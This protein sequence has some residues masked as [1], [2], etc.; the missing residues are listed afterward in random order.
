LD[1]GRV[2]PHIN[3]RWFFLNI[4]C[5]RAIRNLDIHSGGILR[6]IDNRRVLLD[7]QFRALFMHAHKGFSLMDLN[8]G[9]TRFDSNEWITHF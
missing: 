1:F 9:I 2:I 8:P 3:T 4:H 5:G 7:L 6:N